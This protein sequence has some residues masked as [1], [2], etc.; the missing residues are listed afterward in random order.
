MDQVPQGLSQGHL[1]N[2][3][4]YL[5]KSLIYQEPV[6]FSQHESSTFLGFPMLIDLG[7]DFTPFLFEALSL[8]INPKILFSAPSWPLRM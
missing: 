2:M 7:A 6:P 3:F 4:S 5:K 8:N 1:S